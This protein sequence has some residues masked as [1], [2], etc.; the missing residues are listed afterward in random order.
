MMVAGELIAGILCR[1]LTVDNLLKVSDW[2]IKNG[3]KISNRLKGYLDERSKQTDAPSQAEDAAPVPAEIQEEAKTSIREI[4]EKAAEPVYMSGV[5]LFFDCEISG[6]T[7][8]Y[9]LAY[10]NHYNHAEDNS[11]YD[12]DDL[13]W[14]GEVDDFMKHRWYFGADLK[15]DEDYSFDKDCL[16][17]NIPSDDYSQYELYDATA[18]RKLADALNQL[19][20]DLY[21]VKFAVY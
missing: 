16:Y 3:G 13:K 17:L 15:E 6:E 9:L 2:I 5:A 21:I 7:K 11:G 20:G 12:D 14:L 1:E 10:L 4:L 19:L 8:E 18:V